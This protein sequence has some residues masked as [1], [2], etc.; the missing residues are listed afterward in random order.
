MLGNFKYCNPTRVYFGK[1]SLSNLK[2][3]LANYGKTSKLFEVI[4]N[5]IVKNLSVGGL[6]G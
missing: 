5:I 1:D 2:A 4:K 6:K 3:E